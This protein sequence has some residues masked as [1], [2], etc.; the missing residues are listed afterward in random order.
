MQRPAIY[1]LLGFLATITIVTRISSLRSALGDT[2]L[3]SANDRSRWCTVRALVDHGTY[4]IDEVIFK[5][6]GLS[7][8]R[9]T[10]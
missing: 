8:D 9:Y 3:L 7:F 5:P 1:F 6:D 4:E 10:R 2:P